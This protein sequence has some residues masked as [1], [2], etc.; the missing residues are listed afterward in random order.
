L[1][2]NLMN[3]T[4]TGSRRL[5][6]YLPEG[7]A[8]AHKTGTTAIV[9]NDV[10]LITLPVDGRIGGRLALAVYVADGSSIGA[11]E[12][13]VAQLGAA[14]FEFFSG[15]ILSRPQSPPSKRRTQRKAN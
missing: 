4:M 8:V 15:R 6:R 13:T 7:T 2:L 10:G 5:K 9:I 1:L 12:R 3:G 11:M 14:A